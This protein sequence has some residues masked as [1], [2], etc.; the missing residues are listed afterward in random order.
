MRKLELTFDH[1]GEI[2]E[3][4]EYHYRLPKG[5]YSLG[6]HC[7]TYLSYDDWRILHPFYSWECLMSEIKVTGK[8]PPARA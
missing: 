4:D 3:G 7:Q 1:C 2:E 5:W 6:Y 8:E